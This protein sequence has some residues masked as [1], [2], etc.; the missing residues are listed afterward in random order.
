MA[1]KRFITASY[2]G[3]STRRFW[4]IR[5]VSLAIV[6]VV[7]LSL[8]GS[9]ASAETVTLIAGGDVEW[10]RHIWPREAGIKEECAGGWITHLPAWLP[11]RATFVKILQ[12]LFG[13]DLCLSIPLVYTDP[14]DYQ[15]RF[16]SVYTSGHWQSSIALDL[17]GVPPGAINDHPFARTA[18]LL[19]GAD[20]AFVNLE[21][22][23][24]DRANQVGSF[25]MSTAFAGALA[26]A[27]IDV[28]STANNHAL[29]A[30]STGLQDTLTALSEY[31]IG[32]VGSGWNLTAARQAM[33][34][35]RKGHRFAFLAYAQSSN[36]E[37]GFALPDRAGIAPLDPD[38]MVAD[39]RAIANSDNIVIVSLHWERQN[40]PEIHPDE[41]KI[42]RR[43]VDA[44]A[45]LVLGH[46][47]HLPRGVEIYHGGMIVHSL[48]NF[49]FGHW[50]DDWT[51][52]YLARVTFDDGRITALELLP[53]SGRGDDVGQPYPLDGSRAL[54]LLERLRKQSAELDTNLQI[55]G[56]VGLVRPNSE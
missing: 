4:A 38:L 40:T 41:Q 23:M 6:F 43:L 11:E 47:P 46:G 17:S 3:Y 45:D 22:P 29:D 2:S 48:G 7:N 19:R 56:S 44:G 9:L 50:H 24:S 33:I 34:V 28:V 13:S 21:A 54:A 1:Q 53:I 8:F 5:R 51:D 37:N 42:A 49:V 10:S 35:E 12:R 30:E 36:I 52:N 15:H 27:G 39:I 26:R 14:A 31:E 55:V 25:L 20:I 32:A 16:G 18:D